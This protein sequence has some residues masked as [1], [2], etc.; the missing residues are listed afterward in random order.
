MI[1]SL[2]LTINNQS[3]KTSIYCSAPSISTSF[4]SLN[5]HSY[6]VLQKYHNRLSSLYASF[7]SLSLS[8]SY[9][10][11]L[12]SLWAH[13]VFV[14]KKKTHKNSKINKSEIKPFNNLST[15]KFKFK[16]QYQYN[17]VL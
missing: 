11:S 1:Q 10:I 17:N 2:S 8:L 16:Y 14:Q 6:L 9:F 13:H 3:N 7:G 4:T 12:I 15:L 5:Q